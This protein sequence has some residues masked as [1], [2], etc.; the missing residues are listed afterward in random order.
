MRILPLRERRDDIFGLAEFYL[1]QQ[2]AR[3]GKAKRLSA[4]AMRL[5]EAYDFPGNV[6]ELVSIVQKAFVMS[7]DDDLTDALEEALA[8]DAA[9]SASGVAPRSLSES[10]DQT[11]QRRLREAMAACRTTR[12]MAAYLGVSQATV[13]RKLKRYALTRD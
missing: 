11:L 1:A 2:N 7:E 6:R 5:L 3:H 4:R 10:T 9:A 12:E 8:G 13:V